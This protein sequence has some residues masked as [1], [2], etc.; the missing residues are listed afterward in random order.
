MEASSLSKLAKNTAI[1]KIIDIAKK[2]CEENHLVPI[3]SFYLEDNLLTS[4]VKDL[5]PILKNIFKQYGYD[6]SIFIRK[7]EEVLDNAKREDIIEF[8]YYAIPIS[9]ESEITFV[10]NNLVPAKAIVN[11]GT[12]RFI[13]MP[14][15]SYS[16]LNEAISKQGED[17]VLVT[18]ENGK[19]VNIEKKRSIFMESK[20]VDKVVEA[21]KVIIN[22]TPTLDTF[23]IPSIIAMNVKLL[24]NKVIIKK[25]NESLSYEILSGKVDSNEVI[26]GNTL[27]STTKASIYYDFKKKTIIQENII[28]GILNKM[29]I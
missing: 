10:E 28:D 1:T 21:D 15:P 13:F 11:K 20:S 8:P 14:Y 12:F 7:A 23:L 19:I 2:Y 17:D 26:K 5:E 3:L 6:R 4:L 22:L 16:S 27:D 25:N 29:P 18:F 24:E 9:E